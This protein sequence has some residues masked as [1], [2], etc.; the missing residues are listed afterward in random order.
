ME[1]YMAYLRAKQQMSAVQIMARG[2]SLT[3]TS[4]RATKEVCCQPKTRMRFFTATHNCDKQA[5]IQVRTC[6]FEYI[7]VM[8]EICGLPTCL[9]GACRA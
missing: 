7:Y 2:C 8:T 6:L 5:T 1:L 9:D 3:L 4:R